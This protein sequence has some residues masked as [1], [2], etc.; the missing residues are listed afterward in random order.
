MSYGLFFSTLSL[1]GG[2]AILPLG[3]V[4]LREN[5][6]AAVNRA[7]A[8]MLFSG[9]LGSMLGAIGR[10]LEPSDA[11]AGSS[12]V[13]LKSFSYLWEFFFPS[14][15]YFALVYPA[16]VVREARLHVVEAALYVPYLC[17]LALVLL[18][19]EA[20]L[21]D[22]AVDVITARAGAGR[23]GDF[24]AGTLELLSFL[25]RLLGQVHQ[26][27]FALVNVSYAAL[28]IYLLQRSGARVQSV[29]VR[30][31][32]RI[33]VAGLTL[34]VVGYAL[35][36]II[37]ILRYETP[38]DVPTVILT[39][40]S[41]LLATGTIGW[42]IVRHKFLDMR[43]LARRSILY[44][45]T[46]VL[47]AGFY[48]VVMKQ[49]GRLTAG[50]FGPNAD[51]IEAGF[52]VV[53]VLVFQPLLVGAEEALESF[54]RRRGGNDPQA[55]LQQLARQLGS[56]VDV[57]A[58]R[59]RVASS[60]RL[61]LFVEGAALY[62]IEHQDGVAR[63]DGGDRSAP[64]HEGSPVGSLVRFFEAAREPALR[65]DVER[66]LR[67]LSAAERV[68]LHAWIGEHALLIPIVRHDG[69]SGLLGVGPKL[70]GVRFH[71]ED[72][73]LLALVAQQIG[74]S[75]DNLRLV[76]ENLQK[77]V[78]EDELQLAAQIQKGLLPT[79]FPCDRGYRTHALSLAS[80]EVGGD[81][82]DIFVL[83]DHLYLAIADVSGKGVPAALLM[84]SLRAALRS[85]VQHLS[86]PAQVLER[87]NDLLFEST[88]PEKFATFFFGVLD[89]CTHELVFANAGHNYPM[90]VRA[91]GEVQELVQGGLVLGIFP[92]TR[93]TDGLARLDDGDTLFLYTDGVTEASNVQEEEFGT[94][95]LQALLQQGLQ[96]SVDEVVGDVLGAVREFASASDPGDDITMVVVR[97]A[98]GAG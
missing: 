19:G 88:S 95:R 80:K 6:R 38:S 8:L 71:G 83:D 75:L 51:V 42:A 61:S 27:I 98:A 84:A 89:L 81:Y 64:L 93:Y 58:L 54:L 79:V 14:L 69:L 85:N 68:E 78:M 26:Q 47:F 87:I 96:R 60:L 57:G 90:I 41:L 45:A 25:V 15:L 24:V 1:V 77:R 53:S 31:Q 97:R 12:A 82:F 62:T 9:A 91:G 50:V 56:E 39:S 13:W 10:L 46:A 4:I 2:L 11:V 44:G 72:V 86:S 36:K 52:I 29:R 67:S 20:G 35:A 23:M 5:P 37:P 65:Q 94:D 17:H 73:G 3:L 21:G 49:L 92:G 70:S 30:G 33:I 48:M 43:N 28:A 76:S 55:Q 34:C 18:A 59:S 66:S 7:T 16:G 74:A 32:L 63:L 40:L 22:R